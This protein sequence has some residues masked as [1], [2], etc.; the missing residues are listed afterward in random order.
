MTT[1]KP[2]PPPGARIPM[3]YLSCLAVEDND[4]GVLRAL[5][6]AA[7]EHLRQGPWHYAIAGV[8]EADPL[9]VVLAACEPPPIP[10][11]LVHAGGPRPPA[12]VRAFVEFAAERLRR[13]KV[14][15]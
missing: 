2:L 1:R 4:V 10:V 14:L 9:A 3:V 8:H 11:H 7:L 13:E 6:H 15:R 5:L 12:K